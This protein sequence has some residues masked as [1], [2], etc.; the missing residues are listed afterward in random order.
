VRDVTVAVLLIA[1]VGLEV[2]SA[3]GVAAMPSTYDRLHYAGTAGVGAG[4]IGVAVTVRESF[5]LIGNKALLAGVFLALTSPVLT[6]YTAR[7]VRAIR[8]GTWTPRDEE[9]LE[10]E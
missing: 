7:S 4:L 5:S 8:H 10:V 9:R 1:G 2:L 3:L 6:H